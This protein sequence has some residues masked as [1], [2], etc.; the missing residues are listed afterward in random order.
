MNREILVSYA[1]SF[2]SFL[3]ADPKIA[4][5][6]IKTVYLFGSVSRGDFDKDSD[7]DIFIDS[8]SK[9][10]GKHVEMAMSKF[11]KSDEW[12][13]FRLM[14]IENKIKVMHG[15]IK[16]WELYE[17]VKNDGLVLYSSSVSEGLNSFFLVNIEPI[18]EITKRN[19]VMRK[20]VGR[21]EKYY[22]G[23]GLVEG[24]GGEVLDNRVFLVPS[25]KIKSFLT[26]FSKEKVNY[27]IK[28]IW[29]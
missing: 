15:A 22:K 29:K 17:S 18:S 2:V 23:G 19:R 12:K 5:A 26:I 11:L 4:D 20:L 28:K 3:F 8:E 6:R 9:E 13:K 24:L 14:G 1:Y 21:K 25:E 27:R 10:I 7:I 16:R